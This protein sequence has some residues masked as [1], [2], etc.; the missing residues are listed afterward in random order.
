MPC[1]QWTTGRD[2][3]DGTTLEAAAQLTC[4][5]SKPVMSYYRSRSG[6]T[7]GTDDAGT[8][9]SMVCQWSVMSG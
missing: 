7:V 6:A 3:D 2:T 5:V 8:T 1:E 4:N 9:G